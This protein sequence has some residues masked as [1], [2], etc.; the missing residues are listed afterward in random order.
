M[1]LFNSNYFLKTFPFLSTFFCFLLMTLPIMPKGMGEITPVVG[2]IVLSFWII[3]RQDLLP[4]YSVF[5]LG[6]FHDA[7]IGTLFGI[8]SLALIVIKLVVVGML[9]QDHRVSF[10]RAFFIIILCLF[11]W[12]A[13]TAIPVLIE[14]TLSINFMPIVFQLLSSII[15]APIAIILMSFFLNKMDRSA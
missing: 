3:F 2:V 12:T 14:H 1:N 4:Y 7:M 10:L 15:I 9:D 11:L 8:G 5:I 6:L 13:I